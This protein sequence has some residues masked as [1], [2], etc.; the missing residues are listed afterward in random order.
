M[1]GTF[2]ADTYVVVNQTVLTENDKKTL[3]S[4][5]EPIV[6]PIAVSLYL[7]LWSDLDKLE[8]VSISYTH[9]HLMTI[10]KSPLADIVKARKALEALGLLKSFVKANENISEYIYELY[11]PMSPSE[12]FNHPIL[13]ILLLNN[14]GEN[15][16][17]NLVQ[18]YKKHII[19]KDGFLEIT[20]TM[21][22]TFASKTK[23]EAQKEDIRKSSKAS[24][25]LEDIIDFD[26]LEV[27]IPKGMIN[28]K[29]FNK[30]TRELINQLAY[31]YN[32]DTVKMSEILRLVIDEFGLVKKE[33]LREAAR[34]NYEYNH[35]GNLPTIVYRTQPEHLKTPVG[36][37]SNRAKMIYVFENTKPYDFLKSKNKGIKPTVRDLKLMENLAV[38]F[39]LPA[40]V[41][42]VLIDYALRV[43]DGKLNQKYLEA[44][45]STWS[46]KGIKTVPEAMEAAEKGHKRI[47]KT[48][49]TEKPKTEVKAPAWMYKDNNREEM[50][51]EELK[52]LESMFE[53]F[54]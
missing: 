11:S 30:R 43:S 44:I 35:N 32:I 5:Y 13:N 33:K 20:S 45:A 22:K 41:I 15:E 51:E 8:I 37:T 31:I 29:T 42:N 53:E 50:S 4:L 46:R 21:N 36:D 54:R 19:K 10:L 49:K 28:A 26:L 23:F 12:F 2:P 34:K 14:I 6:G 3:I 47:V 16:Y 17:N 52:E 48:V 18:Y 7:T 24:V 39:E 25:N 1:K 9:H 38:D 27:S 40:G